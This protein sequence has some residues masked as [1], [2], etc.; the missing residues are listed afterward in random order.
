MCLNVYL[1]TSDPLPERETEWISV[2]ALGAAYADVRQRF[3]LP[4]V[5]DV[6]SYEG[7]GCGFPHAAAEEPIEYFEGMFDEG[8]PERAHKIESARALLALMAEARGDVELL[9]A[10]AG[11]EFEPPKGV[12]E[13]QLET[14][15][16]ETLV[17][18]QRVLY[19]VRKS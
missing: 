15:T 10:W 2:S 7:C 6:G 3:S 11:D 8:D 5:Q 1:A 19:R 9:A 13:L 18:T 12:V 17:L 16:P 14:L 4:H